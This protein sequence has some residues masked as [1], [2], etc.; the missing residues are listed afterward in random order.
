MLQSHKIASSVVQKKKGKAIQRE[1]CF[2]F[3]FFATLKCVLRSIILILQKILKA[4]YVINPVVRVV[5]SGIDVGEC[6]HS[7]YNFLNLTYL[8]IAI[9]KNVEKINHNYRE[10]QYGLV[11]SDGV[12]LSNPSVFVASQQLNFRIKNKELTNSTIIRLDQLLSL[13]DKNSHQRDEKV[14]NEPILWVIYAFKTFFMVI[15]ILFLEQLSRLWILAGSNQKTRANWS[16]EN[17]MN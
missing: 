17:H 9:V 8:I 16:L 4:E 1:K 10:D 14:D 5:V 6:G 11:L 7:V 2:P 13:R 12:T 15:I 3:Y